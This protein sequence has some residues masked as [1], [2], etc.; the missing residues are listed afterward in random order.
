MDP[1][2][3]MN[4]FNPANRRDSMIDKNRLMEVLKLLIAEPGGSADDLPYPVKLSIIQLYPRAISIFEKPSF[5]LVKDLVEIDIDCVLEILEPTEEM[6]E[7]A[8]FRRPELAFEFEHVSEETLIACLPVFADLISL[9]DSPSAEIQRVATDAIAARRYSD[10]G[11]IVPKI[12]CRDLRFEIAM[13]KPSSLRWMRESDKFYFKVI[14]SNPSAIQHINDPSEPLQINAILAA[15]YLI[16][17]ICSWSQEDYEIQYE[18]VATDFVRE[19]YAFMVGRP[20]DFSK[21]EW[22]NADACLAMTLDQDR[23]SYAEILAN[24][25]LH[26]DM[27]AD[28]ASDDESNE[29]LSPEEMKQICQ[30][31]CFA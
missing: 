17:S 27:T 25:Y 20:C 26:P 29:T 15:P 31:P 2:S 16:R 19:L 12:T 1:M 30:D 21:W 6:K 8:I 13:V 28:D 4:I 11:R 7:Y 9:L 14:G 5:D 18:S 24:K 22:L 10:L 3:I 23:M